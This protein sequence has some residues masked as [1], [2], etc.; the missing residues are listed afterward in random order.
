MFVEERQQKILEMLREEGKVSVDILADVF[1]VSAPTIRADLGALETRRLL[2]RTHGGAIPLE[3]TLY[4]P[5][6]GVRE[7]SQRDE[8]R[9]IARIAA[10]RVR[11]NETVLLDAGT[12]VTEMTPFL[13]E[14]RGLTVVTNSLPTAF[15]LAE[16][17]SVAV[18]LI[19]G[20]VHSERRATLGPLATEFLR[21]MNVDRAFIGI[22]GAN[23][24]AGWTVIDF[25]AAQVKRSMM[26]RAR[27]VVV[28][29]DHSKLG[30]ATFASIGPLS[31]AQYLITDAPIERDSLRVALDAAGVEVIQECDRKAA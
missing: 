8:K 10:M 27:E 30:E 9:R 29:A 31:A 16:S 5:P 3:T 4:E 23:E 28:V 12:T 25:D 18:V 26:A 13:L 6:F 19:G 24:D 14:R 17:G 20:Q 22:N 21:D 7:Q 1:G 11:D 15:E 2:R